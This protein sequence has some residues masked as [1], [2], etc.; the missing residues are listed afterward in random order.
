MGFQSSNAPARRES[1]RSPGWEWRAAGWVARH[2]GL[3]LTPGAVGMGVAELG[4]TGMA[5]V[6][7]GTGA[8]LLGW[9]RGHPNSYDCMA[10]PRL[11][12]VQRRWM[13]RYTGRA[14]SDVTMS[15]DLAPTHRR[16]GAIRVPRI[17]RVRSYSPSIDTVWI[18]LVPGQSPATWEAKSVELAD[19]LGVVRVAVERVRPQIIALVVERSEPFTEVIDAPVMPAESDMVDLSA[20]YLGEDEY[21]AD[22]V[23]KYTGQ[24]ILVAGATG[25]GKASPVWGSLR[26]M[27]PMI[28]DGLVRPWFVDPKRIE[29][30]RGKDV[31]FRYA[32]EPDDCL[33][34]IEEFAEDCRAT[35]RRLSAEG[36]AKFVVSRETPL[37]ILV[38]DELAALLSFGKYHRDIRRLM[39]EIGTQGRATGHVMLGAVQEPSKDVVPVRDLFTVRICLR[40]TSAS[41][42]DMVLGD[43]ARLRGAMADEI[44][45][46]PSTAGIGFVIRTRS[47]VPARVRAAYVNDAEVAE[48]VDFVTD[49]RSTLRAVS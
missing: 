32:A 16:T 1:S 46:D 8:G 5:G 36:K 6:A 39:E 42:V 30:S 18:R 43:G 44:P 15:C 41:H 37:N 34:L 48:L 20:V 40:V 28:R 14:W 24:H 26:S 11:R 3:V 10:A 4:V 13:S 29:L 31:A 38:L 33:A 45:N 35:Q 17:I 22:W 7:A 27:A 25:A 21:G 49:G 23:E 47:C 9:Y 12:A 2:P 19:A